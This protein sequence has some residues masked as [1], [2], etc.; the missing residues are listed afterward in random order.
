M[1]NTTDIWIVN[2]TV[3]AVKEA[4]IL[5]CARTARDLTLYHQAS[6][7]KL[8]KNPKEYGVL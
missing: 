2:E 3:D 5:T 7:R 8:G 1:I 6:R 4:E